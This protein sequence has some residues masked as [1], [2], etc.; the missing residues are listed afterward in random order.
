MR[1]K[2]RLMFAVIA[3]FAVLAAAVFAAEAAENETE[4]MSQTSDFTKYQHEIDMN[5]LSD[6]IYGGSKTTEGE[7]INL[8]VQV[9]T[10]W[11]R[12][13]RPASL[14]TVGKAIL[15]IGDEGKFGTVKMSFYPGQPTI[16]YHVKRLDELKEIGFEPAFSDWTRTESY[17]NTAF[18][19]S[20]TSEFDVVAYDENWVA[21]WSDGGIDETRGVI[22]KCGEKDG[23]AFTSW[24]PGVYFAPRNNCYILDISNQVTAPPQIEA[25]GKVTAPLLVKTTPDENDYVKSGVYKINQSVQIVDAVPQNGH[26]KIYYKGGLYYV[27][28]KYVN[29]QYANTQKPSISY[30][31]EANTDCDISDGSSVVGSVKKGTVIDVIQ[32]DYDGT[33]SKIYFNSKECIIPTSN[34]SN[35]INIPSASGVAKV[36]SPIG[37]IAVDSP[38]SA[39]GVAA[40]T[41]EGYNIIKDAISGNSSDTDELI[42][43]LIEQNAMSLL[44]E[45]DWANVY[46]I[47]DYSYAPD[48]DYP[49]YLET[50]KIYT[51]LYDGDIR[52]IVQSDD[53]NQAF[54][55]YSENDYSKITVAKTQSVC[56]E[57]DK[58]NAAAYNIDDNN[59]FKLRDIAEMLN[60]TIKTF[61]IKY[62]GATNSIDMLSFYDYTPAGGELTPGDGAERTAVTS[63]A[64][65]TLDGVPVQATCYNIEGNNYFKLRDITDALDCRVEWEPTTQTIWVIPSRTAYDDPDEVVG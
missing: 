53:E 61:D 27:N 2:L 31:A 18:Y 48:P 62:D 17:A 57:N 49:D 19:A 46:K 42:E 50:G 6:Y 64:F 52:Y 5:F 1:K 10:E 8:Y 33:N 47:E 63:S 39:Y 36:G 60:G 41:E 9:P 65:L 20:V 54:T 40:Y 24:K 12:H 28:A 26:Y 25:V 59:Y 55:Y 32:K 4:K 22:V 29:I 44:N 15:H 45:K 56:I 30:K 38:W 11:V 35:F 23:T 16:N 14:P 3:A 7:E 51:I 34:L 37:V 43:K 13:K 21:V 58:Y